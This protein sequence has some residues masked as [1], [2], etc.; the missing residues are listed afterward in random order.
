MNITH[1]ILFASILNPGLAD[2][3]NGGSAH[4]KIDA[5]HSSVMFR[6][7]HLGVSNCYG[8][9]NAFGGEFTLDAA[10]PANCKLSITIQTESID[11]NL[12][13]RDKHLKSPD[14]FNVKQYPTATFTSKSFKQSADGAYDVAGDLTMHGV[15]KEVSV[16]LKKIG[17]GKDPFGGYRAG[18]ETEFEIKRADYGINFM[19][20]GLGAD[21]RILVALE[22][23]RS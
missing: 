14:F 11:S 15:T 1:L 23:V 6:V 13:A 2:G 3:Q 7:S 9:F 5:G 22:G 20:E 12:A 10:N 8:R 4:Y 19:P 17:E 16:R 18:F 21:V